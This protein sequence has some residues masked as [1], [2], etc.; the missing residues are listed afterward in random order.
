MNTLDELTNEY[1]IDKITAER[2]LDGYR[3]R[4][5]TLSG[6]LEIKDVTYKG[7]GIKEVKMVCTQCGREYIS[8]IKSGSYKWTDL[9]HGCECQKGRWVSMVVGG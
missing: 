2:M 5:G 7:E 4:V 9:R 6:V 1:G 8:N 3:E